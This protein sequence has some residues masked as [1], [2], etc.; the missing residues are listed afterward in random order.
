MF[1][2]K[3][4]F[5]FCV[6]CTIFNMS[7]FAKQEVI[8]YGDNSYPPYS[9]MEKGEAKGIYVDILTK[10]FDKMTNYKI[11]IKMI[12]WKRGIYYIKRGNA[13]ALFPP[14][15]SKERL[16]WMEFSEPIIKEEIAVFGK[17]KKLQGKTKWPEDFY[18]D[19]IGINS[20]F[21]LYTLGGKK[22][23]DAVKNGKIKIDAMGGNR[24]NLKKLNKDRFDFYIND[25]LVDISSHPTIK[26]GM[27]IHTN[28]GHLGFTQQNKQYTFSKEF[29]D[30]FNTII[31]DMKSSGEIQKILEDYMK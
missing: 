26:R 2:I 15:Y 21:G 24:T 22:F 14:Y 13:F 25:K 5:L 18:G 16:S 30:E 31:N 9:Y 12:P 20:G 7:L 11:T 27:V 23:G 29:Q 17:E 6:L 4:I 10:A 1:Q 3:K 19:T 8:I 28:D